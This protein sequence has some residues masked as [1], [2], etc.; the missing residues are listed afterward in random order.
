MIY[1]EPTPYIVGLVN[2]V[3]KKAD[4]EVDV[5]FLRENATQQWNLSIAGINAR[6]L[7][8]RVSEA[9]ITL[10]CIIGR[11]GYRVVHLAGW[12]EKL[13]LFALVMARIL[14]VPVV[15]E[16]DTP[17]PGRLP[18]WKVAVKRII[19]PLLF[20]AA[21]MLLP[22]GSRQAAY[23]RHYG[24]RDG[25]IMI[26]CMTVDVA[27]IVGRCAEIGK[28]G[29]RAIRTAFGFAEDDIVFV[30]VG[31]LL[32][33]KGVNDLLK[34]FEALSA[35]CTD[36]RLVIAGDG[37]LREAVIN[38]AG[39]NKSIRYAGR[40]DSLEVITILH[41]GD[42]AVVP[43][44]R[45][46]WGLVVNEAMA[47]GLPVIAT[48]AVGC[49]DDLVHENITGKIIKAKDVEALTVAMHDMAEHGEERLR[50]GREALNMIADWT[51]EREAGMIFKSWLVVAA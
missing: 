36:V 1:V 11:G 26:A 8:P 43:S 19:Y 28:E 35:R 44:H 45:E 42:I 30:F 18:F 32:E 48:D 29:R 12:S 6:I 27:H 37:P 16:S 51:L 5:I 46:P 31:R 13:I 38:E 22:G 4:G 14:R 23:F 40:L 21:G 17:L 41:A 39:Q 10:V 50:M 24:V 20:S 7:S 25:R 34:G 3:A 49:V 9:V 47:A 33:W 15:I 2:E